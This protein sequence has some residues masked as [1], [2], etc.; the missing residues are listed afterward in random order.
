MRYLGVDFG[1]KKIGLAISDEK[2]QMAFPLQTILYKSDR[3]VFARLK[4]IVEK[5]QIERI[6]AGLPVSIQKTQTDIS[7]KV[8]R[9]AQKLSQ[10][11]DLSVD[12]ER[13]FMT[14]K[15][16][17]I[18]SSKKIDEASAALILQSY[19]DRKNR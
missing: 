5:N 16:A 1:T 10:S 9:F 17:K 11:T 8:E 3:F 2:G 19:L 13:E 14:T 15:I 4:E 6:V 18:S 12:F 7:K